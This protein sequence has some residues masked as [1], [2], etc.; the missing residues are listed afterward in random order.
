[1]NRE[2][3]VLDNSQPLQGKMTTNKETRRFLDEITKMLMNTPIL[4]LRNELH[5]RSYPVFTPPVKIIAQSFLREG[6]TINEEKEYAKRL[7]KSAD[8]TV[9]SEQP[10]SIVCHIDNTEIRIDYYNE[11]TSYVF[12]DNQADTQLF[13]EITSS[14][15][16]AWLNDAPGKRLTGIRFLFN[17]TEDRSI[18]K[19]SLHRFFGESQIFASSTSHNIAIVWSNFIADHQGYMNVLIDDFGLGP[20]RAGRLV[21]RIIDIENYRMM[22]L[23]TLPI[24]QKI[25]KELDRID[26]HLTRLATIFPE[27]NTIVEEKQLLGELFDLMAENEQMRALTLRRFIGTKAY[28][29][30]VDERLIELDCKPVAGYQTFS[31][32][33]IRRMRPAM[34]TCKSAQIRLEELSIHLQRVTDMFSTRV[35]VNVEQQNQKILESVARQSKM[36]VRLQQMVE[37]LSIVAITYYA[38]SLLSYI[39]KSLEY[40]GSL[41]SHYLWTGVSIPLVLIA[42]WTALKKIK[43]KVFNNQGR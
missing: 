29:N 36:Q 30:I 8:A 13:S 19:D 9:T 4:T 1:M 7:I 23:L 34:R 5:A 27:R 28:Q 31:T 21:Q 20:R 24:A 14:L 16:N 11:Y 6:C 10:S 18:H 26:S 42:T 2:D 17:K 43:A 41:N 32:F 39:Y 35:N 15:D 38:S 33:F 22:S 3:S 12:I 37:G 25:L 40:V